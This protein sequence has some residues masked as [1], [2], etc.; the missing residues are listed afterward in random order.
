MDNESKEL[1]ILFGIILVVTLFFC[2]MAIPAHEPATAHHGKELAE[3]QQGMEH[4]HDADEH[5]A[6]ADE[7]HGGDAHDSAAHAEA[8]PAHGGEKKAEPAEAPME[9]PDGY[10][11]IAMNNPAYETHKKGIVIFTHRKHFEDYGIGCGDCH[12]DDSGMPL[13]DLAEGDDVESCIDC[14]QG[15]QKPKGEKLPK[16]EAI[17][18]YHFEA[19]HANCIG[20]HKTYNIEHG[21]PKGKKPAPV[22]CGACHPKVKK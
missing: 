17:M 4:G 13:E 1:N 9:E 8:A 7:A 14:H 21:D 3:H 15:T 19:L 16:D 18:A 11:L 22:S 20:C 2:Y 6:P 12:H 5:A 10:D